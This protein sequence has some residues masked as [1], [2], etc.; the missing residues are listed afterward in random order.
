[1]IWKKVE[2]NTAAH[3]CSMLYWHLHVH[4]RI[5]QRLAKTPLILGLQE[6]IFTPNQSGC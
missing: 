3:S 2:T 6:T 5:D 1:M 4:T